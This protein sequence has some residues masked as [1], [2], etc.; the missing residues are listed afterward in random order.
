MPVSM[1]ARR[2]M[3]SPS[4]S[5]EAD[6]SACIF[7]RCSRTRLS[8]ASVMMLCSLAASVANWGS[9]RFAKITRSTASRVWRWIAAAHRIIRRDVMRFN[10]RPALAGRASGGAGG[11]AKAKGGFNPR[12]ALAGRASRT[13]PPIESN[14]MC[15]NPRPALAGRAS[16]HRPRAQ[17]PALCF[18]PRPALAGR[19]SVGYLRCY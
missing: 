14:P 16:R 17:Q 10:P 4:R 15:F 8:T 1:C 7:F 18:N 13:W 5:R 9:R 6:C 11:T 2:D 12:P 19:A 3:I